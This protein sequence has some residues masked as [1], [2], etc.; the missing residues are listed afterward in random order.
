MAGI[1]ELVQS[2]KT[3]WLVPA[4]D[5]IALAD[6]MREALAA[7]AKQLAAMGA[8]GRLHILK[9]HDT[10]KE[11]VKLKSLFETGVSPNSFRIRP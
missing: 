5:E 3:G 7:P 10:L 9:Q 8:E 11:V 1:P 4:G 6:V 2:G